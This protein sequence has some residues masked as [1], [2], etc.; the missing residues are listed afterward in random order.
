MKK[1]KIIAI[2]VIIICLI[3]SVSVLAVE[4]N[5]LL[6][7][8]QYLKAFLNPEQQ[9]NK[10]DDPDNIVA[11]YHDNVITKSVIEH[12]RNM[13]SLLQ[14]GSA[15]NLSDYQLV[16]LLVR[17]MMIQEEAERLGVSATQAEIDTFIEE[18]KRTFEYPE[19]EEAM[20]EYFRSA[21]IT[22]DEYFKLLKESAPDLIA[23][24]KL[25]VEIGRQYCEK[26]GLVF[27]SNNPSQEMLDAV[28]AY[29]EE[30]FEANKDEIVYYIE[31]E[32]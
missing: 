18:T 29:I 9:N 30:L 3:C 25:R 31:I 14:D 22:I 6:Q 28:D 13:R 23:T 1:G 10:I 24:E 26:H 7:A 32:S 17:N 11:A 19:V 15:D 5:A 21:G 27:S 4:D 12:Q 20:D 8:G 16:N 2:T